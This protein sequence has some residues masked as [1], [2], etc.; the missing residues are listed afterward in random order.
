MRHLRHQ[1]FFEELDTSLGALGVGE[2][3]ELVGDWVPT[4]R[5][6]YREARQAGTGDVPFVD[7]VDLRWRGTLACSVPIACVAFL[8]IEGELFWSKSVPAATIMH[9]D[10]SLHAYADYSTDRATFAASVGEAR[11]PGVA[12]S[13]VKD[14]VSICSVQQGSLTTLRVEPFANVGEVTMT[15]LLIQGRFLQVGRHRLW[16]VRDELASSL[17]PSVRNMLT[18]RRSGSISAG[19]FESEA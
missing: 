15:I 8:A 12:V 10:V 13:G 6:T 3:V 5:R 19:T 17:P 18:R 9:V 7:V 4:A 2:S 14:L 11:L 1:P 16:R